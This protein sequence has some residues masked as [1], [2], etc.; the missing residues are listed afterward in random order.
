M[1]EHTDYTDALRKEVVETVSRIPIEYNP[2][3]WEKLSKQLDAE[4]PVSKGGKTGFNMN[5][6][7][8]RFSVLLT[9]A[10]LMLSVT[11]GSE[12]VSSS[13]STMEQKDVEQ[14]IEVQEAVEDLTHSSTSNDSR[15]TNPAETMSSS[16]HP[17]KQLDSS[18]RGD[19][20]IFDQSETEH[21][22]MMPAAQVDTSMYVPE[23]EQKEDSVFIFW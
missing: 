14:E 7:W 17:N 5:G 8:I 3:G 21:R 13:I 18:P 9:V 12:P 22:K 6:K 4:L 15:S 16:E 11:Q 20:S 2:Q 10:V 19:I 23:T 1:L